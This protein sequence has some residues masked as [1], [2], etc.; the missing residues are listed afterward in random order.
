MYIAGIDEVGRGP[1]A[2]PVSIG[3]V[4]VLKSTNLKAKFPLLNDSKKLS[5][6]KRE[7]IYELAKKD[8]D[9]G[10][11]VVSNSARVIDEK[12]IE[13]AI[14]SAIEKGCTKLPKDTTIYLDGRLRAPESFVQE[15]VIGGDAKVPVISLASIMAKVER[16]RYMK[17]ISED[18]PQYGL[19][20]H[21]GYGTRAHMEAIAECGLSDVH[22]VS[23][24]KSIVLAQK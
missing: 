16:D 5:E 23:F 11:V 24:C 8:K 1:L 10:Y 18:Y 12:G 22:R 19:H 15:T 9:I 14:K 17:K 3:I 4:W 6:K 21:K 7:E 2:G 20:K 13:F